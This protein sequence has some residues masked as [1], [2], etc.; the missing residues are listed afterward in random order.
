LEKR[1]FQTAGGWAGALRKGL[2]IKGNS[3]DPATRFLNFNPRAPMKARKNQKLN[4][5]RF[6]R[7][8][9]FQGYFRDFKSRAAP[10]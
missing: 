2:E 10:A 5:L 6:G 8:R 9:S 1:I 3:P 4:N 7:A